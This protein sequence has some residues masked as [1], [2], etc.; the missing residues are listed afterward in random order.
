MRRLTEADYRQAAGRLTRDAH[1]RYLAEDAAPASDRA[2]DAPAD[3]R[4]G[5][6][7]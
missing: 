6:A 5:R 4:P 1:D 7:R 2:A 3:D